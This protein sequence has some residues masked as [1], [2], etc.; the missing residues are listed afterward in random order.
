MGSEMV[1]LTG[2]AMRREEKND[3]RKLTITRCFCVSTLAEQN[4]EP[5]GK[6]SFI[7]H[8]LSLLS[9]SITDQHEDTMRYRSD[10]PSNRLKPS[11]SSASLSSQRSHRKTASTDSSLSA[12]A[13][14]LDGTRLAQVQCLRSLANLCI[15]NDKNRSELI[16]HDAPLFILRLVKDVLSDVDRTGECPEQAQ[17]LLLK[18]AMGALLNM[19]LDHTEVRK[20]LLK[21]PDRQRNHGQHEQ[22]DGI[23]HNVESSSSSSDE[24]KRNGS[25]PELSPRPSTSEDAHLYAFEPSDTVKLLL[26][27][28]TDQKIHATGA[29][30]QA[31]LSEESDEQQ[32]LTAA[33]PQDD[34]TDTVVGAEVS[35]W[36]ARIAEDLLAFEAIEQRAAHPQEL[37]EV[38]ASMLPSPSKAALASD[39][40]VWDM[41]LLPLRCCQPSSSKSKQSQRRSKSSPRGELPED[42]APIIDADVSILSLCGDLLEGCAHISQGK[43][44]AS[45]NFKQHG[46]A[47]IEELLDFIEY[48]VSPL[49][50]DFDPSGDL[51]ERH[52]LEVDDLETLSKEVARAKANAVKAAVAIAGEDA[53]MQELFG[54]SNADSPFLRRM[55]RWLDS[56]EEGKKREDLVSSAL[57]SIANLARSDENCLALAQSHDLIPSIVS[58]LSAEGNSILLSHAALGLLKNLCIPHDNKSLIGST[59][60][61]EALPKFMAKERDQAQPVQ[62]A[63][64]GVAKHLAF[65]PVRDLTSNAVKACLGDEDAT[66]SP[67]DKGSTLEA[68]LAL[69][70]RTEDTPTRLEATRVLVNLIRT[71]W[72]SNKSKDI[73]GSEDAKAE[74]LHEARK[75]LASEQVIDALT[76]MLGR[77]GK[78]PVLINEALVG[79][80]LLASGRDASTGRIIMITNSLLGRP[81]DTRSSETPTPQSDPAKPAI[82]DQA[83][84]RSSE[85]GKHLPK[86][87][88]SRSDTLET[89]ITSYASTTVT[90]PSDCPADTLYD[91][92]WRKDETNK[93]PIQFAENG[94]SLLI[95]LIGQGDKSQDVFKDLSIKMLPAL[96]G[97]KV[98]AKEGSTKKVVDEA[99]ETCERA[100]HS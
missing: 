53:N 11:S 31:L 57:L 74:L 94:C 5:F 45:R 37:S 15:D 52:G 38:E 22:L 41:L 36:A 84:A 33:V 70:G 100:V 42:A 34:W 63:A 6:P 21:L 69:I 4:R 29:A 64:V 85:V 2:E 81:V 51:L 76:D 17:L 44:D 3:H 96:R 87:P 20:W 43:D 30:L 8:L 18:T 93:I 13:A 90:A 98:R 97:L 60:I 66:P 49:G 10:P 67:E 9:L 39:K 79:L 24:A 46:L 65:S 72:Q 88:P 40:A 82:G 48:G 26:K 1:S 50:D 99:L 75:R 80:T 61:F 55:K 23:D 14:Q 47:R 62:F 58:I 56:N 7:S 28:A 68:L 77:G 27:V 95:S 91:I 86:V 35:A 16:R 19:Q 25:H 78:F 54:N 71:L 12:K 73:E 32:K 89:M 83:T 59:V 92:L